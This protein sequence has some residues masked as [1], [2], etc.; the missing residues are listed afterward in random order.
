VVEEGQAPQKFWGLSKRQWDIIEISSAGIAVL[1]TV[2]EAMDAVGTNGIG[3]QFKSKGLVRLSRLGLERETWTTLNTV[4]AVFA[5]FTLTRA[6]YE[7]FKG[8]GVLFQ[9]ETWQSMRAMR[10][11]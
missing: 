3:G 1:A 2:R 10:R 4:G 11:Q 8:K 6:T 9:G 7:N 5:A